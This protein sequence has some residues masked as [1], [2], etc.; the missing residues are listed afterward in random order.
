[1]NPEHPVYIV[2]KG[3]A[4]TMI[5]SRSLSRM[6]VPHYIII[7]PQDEEPYEKALDA[8]NIRHW[9]TLIVAPFSNHGDG[10]GRARNYAWDHAISI[11]AKKHWVMDDNIGD[12]Y[13]LHKSLVYAF[14]FA[15]SSLIDLKM[16]LCLGYSTDFSLRQIKSILRMS[17]TLEFIRV[18]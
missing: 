18:C 14:T 11:G 10:P 5:T 9:V 13:R 12:F 8:F 17:R 3:R 16:F 4:D 6:K 2:S 7:E 1:M 15:N